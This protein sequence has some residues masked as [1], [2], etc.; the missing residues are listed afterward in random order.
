MV[1]SMRWLLLVPLALAGSPAYPASDAPSVVTY[2]DE[3]NRSGRFVMPGLTWDRARHVHLDPKFQGEV[4]GHVYAQP[5]YWHPAGSSS[6]LLIVATEDDTVYALDADSGSTVWKASLGS[7][8]PRS[9]LPCGN[10]NPLGITGTPVIDE[11]SQAVYLDAVVRGPERA[12]AQHM[13]FGLSL[14]DGSLLS[15]W[16]VD[17]AQ[18][19]QNVGFSFNSRDQNQRGSLTIVGE[20]LYIPYG[21]HYGDCG[22]YHGWVVSASLRDPKE[23][24]AW[25]T[26]GR[27]GGIWA[28]GG[29]S[30]DGHS[31]FAATGNTIGAKTWSDGEAIIRLSPD[32]TTSDQPR[33]FFAPANWKE[34]DSA[35]ADLGGT[36]PMPID[37]PG[38]QGLAALLLALGKDGKAY[39]LDRNNL[40]GIGGALVA[41]TVSLGPIRTAPAAYSSGDGVLVAFQG[42]GSNCPSRA[43]AIELT[44]LRIR[45]E[46]KPEVTTAWCGSLRGA[47]A[48][49][50]TIADGT[51][52][53]IVWIVGAEGDNRLHAFQG[54]T[55]EP[56]T[57]GTGVAA[58][59][60]GLRHFVTILA[61]NDHL[62]VA[63]DGRIYAF[64]F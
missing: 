5:L 13:I 41:T 50:V 18:A 34:L 30:Y 62:Y 39:L 9:L 49:I 14:R 25:A 21:G 19:L 31:L 2:H 24:T 16:P 33:D 26:R 38:H 45:A 42:E 56:L 12:P 37:V 58:P 43:T 61:A 36:N 60:K 10:I 27:G 47:G 46:P 54:D 55:G 11:R 28:P 53:P 7:P 20:R 23:V 57:T 3:P 1:R 44:V 6:G 40:G 4:S 48:P 17:A 15:G 22:Q 59:L 29:I 32:L 51:A 52:E 64:G 8:V 35:D 63:A